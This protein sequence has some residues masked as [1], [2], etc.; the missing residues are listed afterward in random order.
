MID[1]FCYAVSALS[2]PLVSCAPRRRPRSPASAQPS[3]TVTCTPPRRGAKCVRVRSLGVVSAACLPRT[4]WR[5]VLRR[6]SVAEGMPGKPLN[7]DPPAKPEVFQLLPPQRG[8][9]AIEERENYQPTE[10]IGNL[11]DIA[12]ILRRRVGTTPGNVKRLLPP[13]QSRGNSQPVRRSFDYSWHKN[14]TRKM[15]L[16]VG[17]EAK[18]SGARLGLRRR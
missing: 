15:V 2:R 13:R 8:L 7:N 1:D 11:S 4:P 10:T 16:E 17:Y 3:Q 5:E 14:F 9:F 6:N 12:T 18:L